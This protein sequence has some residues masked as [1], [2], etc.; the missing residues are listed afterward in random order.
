MIAKRIWQFFA[1]TCLFV[2]AACL[3]QPTFTINPDPAFVG[4]AVTFDASAT[5]AEA[6]A[7]GIKI[8]SAKWSFGDKG[9]D[10]ADDNDLDDDDVKN[11]SKA[12]GKIVQHTYT[13][14]G[15]YSV[16][17]KI[18]DSRGRKSEATRTLVVKTRST[19]SL[20]SLSVNVREASGATVSGATITIGSAT[21]T[22]D[23]QGTA[24]LSNLAPGADQVVTISKPGY[25]SQSL[26]ASVA[27]GNTTKL[28]ARMLAVSQTLAIGHIDAQQTFKAEKLGASISIP[29]NAFVK[30]NGTLATGLVFVDI[31]PWDITNSDLSAM[32]GNGRAKD[33]TGALVNLISAGMVSAEF[34]AADGT[35]L[36]LAPG[37]TA[38]IRMDLQYSSI[39]GQQ[40]DTTSTIPLWHFDETQGLWIEEGIG[41]VVSSNSSPV[42]MALVGT[43]SHFS[44]WNWDFK[45]TNPGSV[46]VQC[47]SNAGVSQACEV[48][49]AV[50]LADGSKYSYAGYAPAG[51]ITV[52]NMPTAATIVWTANAGPGVI[53]T[54][55]SGTSGTVNIPLGPVTTSNQ[56]K[57]QLPDATAVA[58]LITVDFTLAD[59]SVK[60]LPFNIPAEGALMETGLPA[61]SISWN[62]KT[63]LMNFGTEFRNYQGSFTSGVSGS[64]IVTLNTIIVTP[65]SKSIN[66]LCDF[67]TN[68]VQAT[69][70]NLNVFY[71]DN[72]DYNVDLFEGTL[73]AGEVRKI[74]LPSTISSYDNVI[75]FSVYSSDIN[76]SYYYYAY[77]SLDFNTIIDGQTVNL[78]LQGGGI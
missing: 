74:G 18:K 36:Q 42:G 8:K 60:S 46:T 6:Q 44:T 28:A 37:K 51:G 11:T 48:V 77:G 69:T 65:A 19:S 67:N 57:C 54:A 63:K 49:A 3:S 31:T 25:I 32:L 75:R 62:A 73:A 71:Y 55:T 10:K 24:T 64:V 23:A 41:S 9:V 16:K 4:E 52:I 38:K 47:L 13:V 21:V 72:D 20:G 56:V 27:A 50:T 61:S 34:R 78:V 39:N 7:N 22:A 29:Q 45:F 59:G 70:C 68:A 35:K 40:L 14:V 2:L 17:L 15:T 5:Y 30:P 1:V 33:A 53:G 43:V 26:R 12:K 76:N 58:C 66:V